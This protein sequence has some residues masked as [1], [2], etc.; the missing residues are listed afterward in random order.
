MGIPSKFIGIPI[1]WVSSAGIV[2]QK[3]AFFGI[4]PRRCG[5]PMQV[6]PRTAHPLSPAPPPPPLYPATV[7]PCSVGWSVGWF[8]GPQ[9][10]NF[11]KHT[12]T[13]PLT[14]ALF[15]WLHE[16]P[17]EFWRASV[18]MQCICVCMCVCHHKTVTTILDSWIYL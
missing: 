6:R 14:C 18:C 15:I 17:S 12:Y 7:L 8:G 16:I 13:L 3:R 1:N 4:R 2:R 5:A 11:Y 9:I 10:Q